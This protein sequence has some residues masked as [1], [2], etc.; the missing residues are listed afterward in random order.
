MVIVVMSSAASDEKGSVK[1]PIVC[2][3]SQY[4]FRCFLRVD[5]DVQPIGF[6]Y[7]CWTKICNSGP[8]LCDLSVE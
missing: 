7:G 3:L 5:I 8:P 6:H 2:S 4:P 1:F